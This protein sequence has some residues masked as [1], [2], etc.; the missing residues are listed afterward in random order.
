MSCTQVVK[1]YLSLH[2]HNTSPY[3]VSWSFTSIARVHWI[4]VPERE[5]FLAANYLA[6]ASGTADESI[7]MQSQKS[8]MLKLVWNWER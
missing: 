5:V 1:F 3:L 2:S 4:I 7:Q 8:V 6:A